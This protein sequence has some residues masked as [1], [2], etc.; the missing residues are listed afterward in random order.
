MT[1]V[2]SD[3]NSVVTTSRDPV[4]AVETLASVIRRPEQIPP[5]SGRGHRRAPRRGCLPAA[6]P[7][8]IGGGGV[9]PVTFLD[10][11]AASPCR[12]VGRMVRHDRGLLSGLPWEAVAGRRPRHLRRRVADLGGRVPARWRRRRKSTVAT[13]SAG[14]G[15]WRADRATSTDTSADVFSSGTASRRFVRPVRPLMHESSSQ[16][17]SPRSSIRGTRPGCA[18]RDSPRGC[19]SRMSIVRAAADTAQCRSCKAQAD[20]SMCS[21][22]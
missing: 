4:G 9:D 7:L 6:D 14:G 22:F 3:L 15:R 13:G 19:G 20:R 17:G 21:M 10:V 1:A 2:A 11:E 5:R 18:A 8:E 12:R 16:P